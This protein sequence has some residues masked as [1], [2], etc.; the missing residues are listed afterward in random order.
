MKRLVAFAVVAG[1]VIPLAATVGCRGGKSSAE[2]EPLVVMLGP[3][4]DPATASKQFEPLAGYL[5]EQVGQPFKFV[6]TKS[7]DEFSAEVKD[8]K[9]SF[10]YANPLDYA[11]VA[12]ACIILTKASYP[13]TGSMV[14]G[15][16]IVAEGEAI[17]IRDVSE[18]K[19]ASIMIVSDSSLGGYLSQKM[20]FDRSELDLDLDFDLHTAPNGTPEEVIAAVAA[21]EVEYGCVP[22][23]FYPERKPYKGTEVL[24]I[25][26]KVPVEAFGFV[27]MGGDKMLGG[28][29]RDVLKDIPKD[30]PILK[31]LG[32]ENFSLATAAEYDIVTNY[33]AQDKIDKAQRLSSEVPAE[34]G[35]SGN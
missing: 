17:K 26:E 10:V 6:T 20:F 27:E 31:P 28:K 33:L 30:D 32:I 1:L 23:D 9:A 14:Q 13:N 3:T 29:V 7:R 18:L 35:E 5:E 19:G 22:I 15:C 34:T 21:G 16:I 12:D 8:G 24:T 11:E 2:M 25:S 4:F